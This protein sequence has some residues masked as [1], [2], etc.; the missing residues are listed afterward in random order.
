MLW[1][2]FQPVP[3][4]RLGSTADVSGSGAQRPLWS[5]N[6]TSKVA[7]GISSPPKSAYEREAD[8]ATRH[9]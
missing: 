1:S 3:Y 9:I 7:I 4:V 6:Q 2:V 8:V 5:D